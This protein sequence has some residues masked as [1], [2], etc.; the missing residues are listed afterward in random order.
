MQG[1][2]SN[3]RFPG[4]KH[5]TRNKFLSKGRTPFLFCFPRLSLNGV[6]YLSQTK[7]ACYIVPDR[8]GLLSRPVER[9]PPTL[10]MLHLFL[11]HISRV[12]VPQQVTISGVFAFRSQVAKRSCA[13][14]QVREIEKIE[15]KEKREAGLVTNT[16]YFPSIVVDPPSTSGKGFVWCI[17][18]HLYSTYHSLHVQDQTTHKTRSRAERDRVSCRKE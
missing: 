16:I 1:G 12:H 10:P 6:F 11:V 8:I 18:I 7:H 14:Q 15:I 4:D 3:P 9:K 13:G 17:H 5:S 2:S